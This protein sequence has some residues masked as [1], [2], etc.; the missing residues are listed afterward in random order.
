MGR[1]KAETLEC[2]RESDK[3]KKRKS[4]E[5]FLS[6]EPRFQISITPQTE[7]QLLF[8]K[9]LRKDTIIVGQGAPGTGK[10]IGPDEEIEIMLSDELYDQLLNFV[11]A[12]EAE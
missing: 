11:S 4:H 1:K 10:C 3:S 5:K 6:S 8:L 9:S 2:V 12:L 7:N